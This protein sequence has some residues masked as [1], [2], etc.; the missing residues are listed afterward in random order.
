MLVF[1]VGAWVMNKGNLYDQNDVVVKD[2]R[3]SVLGCIPERYPLS[4][5]DGST[6]RF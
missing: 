1:M 4:H 2:Y 6:Y 5:T 3:L